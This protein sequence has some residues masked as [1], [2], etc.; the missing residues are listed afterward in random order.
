MNPI[1]KIMVD[2]HHKKT[3]QKL[4]TKLHLTKDSLDLK[5]KDLIFTP[6]LHLTDY[7]HRTLIKHYTGN[8]QDPS[9]N[10]QTST[11]PNQNYYKTLPI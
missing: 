5:G 1:V 11:A 6:I 2:Y 9:N 7:S 10:K 3:S 4:A 8:M